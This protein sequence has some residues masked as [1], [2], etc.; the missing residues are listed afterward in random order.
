MNRHLFNYSQKSEIIKKPN[1]LTNQT[2]KT[3]NPTKDNE[4]FMALI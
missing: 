3:E 1:Q 4:T 2:R